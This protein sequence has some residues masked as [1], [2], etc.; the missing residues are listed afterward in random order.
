MSIQSRASS[1]LNEAEGKLRQLAAEAASSGDYAAIVKVAAW[2]KAVGDLVR[3][4]SPESRQ[5]P[6]GTP[7]KLGR[8]AKKSGAASRST[9]PS[10]T[11][12]YPRFYRRGDQLFRVAWSKRDK[13]EYLHKSPRSAISALVSALA[14]VGREGRVFSTDELLPLTSADDGAEIPNYQTYVCIAWLKHTGLIEQHGRQGYSIPQLA[15]LEGSVE[16][17]W[18]S[19]PQ[20]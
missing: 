11:K 17:M 16:S 5:N 18:Q 19:L 13:K 2:A 15:Q 14:K 20:Q 10:E 3:S 9:A 4:A 12:A 7:R 8:G 6:T 1:V